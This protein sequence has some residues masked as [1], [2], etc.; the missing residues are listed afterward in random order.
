MKVLLINNTE[1]HCGIYQYGV[2]V[3]HN[4]AVEGRYKFEYE[5]VDSLQRYFDCIDIHKPTHIL[6]NY[7]FLTLPWLPKDLG[8][9]AKHIMIHHENDYPIDFKYDAILDS[10]NGFNKLINSYSL[11]RP[12]SFFKWEPIQHVNELPTIGHFGFA[13]SLKGTHYLV[14]RVH[15]TFKR[16]VINFSISKAKY[17]PSDTCVVLAE[18]LRSRSTDDIKINVSTEFMPE[19]ELMHWLRR[20]DINVFLY[21][22]GWGRGLSSSVDSVISAEAPFAVNES[23]M[24]RHIH[25]TMPELNIDRNHLK[26]VIVLRNA[27]AIRLKTLWNNIKFRN[28]VCT[29]L[30]KS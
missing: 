4:L 17:D 7:H 25:N 29:A 5:E 6:Y 22:I 23:Y 21:D 10:S 3:K 11:S 2:R 1:T 30:E 14:D 12:L 16:A 26:D 19:L 28:D 24:F 13:S 8:G 20:N 18:Q 9:D 15:D 27:P